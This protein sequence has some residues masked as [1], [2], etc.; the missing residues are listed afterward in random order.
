MPDDR[1][2]RECPSG[3]RIEK[4]TACHIPGIRT[5]PLR[6]RV[7]RAKAQ[8]LVQYLIAVAGALHCIA[9]MGMKTRGLFFYLIRHLLGIAYH[10][11][12]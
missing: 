2:R 6:R 8:T 12:L 11:K 4:F 10:S 1:Q 5:V 3:G 7:A 9:L